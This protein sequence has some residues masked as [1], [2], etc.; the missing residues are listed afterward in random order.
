[1]DEV[2][3]ILRTYTDAMTW[4]LLAVMAVMLLLLYR[5]RWRDYALVRRPAAV[6]DEE[7]GADAF[8]RVSIVVPY[9]EGQGELV[10]AALPEFLMLDYPDFEVIATNC[11]TDREAADA[12]SRLCVRHRRLRATGIPSTM[13]DKGQA[14]L[15]VT[16]GV[17]AAYGEW[18][19]ILPPDARPASPDVL[20][21]MVQTALR[22]GL[23]V[24]QA[25]VN[26][27]DEG[28]RLSR[29]A[30]YARLLRQLT[31]L[32]AARRGA[33]IGSE[34]VGVLMRKEFFLAHCHA[35][36][37]LR[38]PFG[39]LDLMLDGQ[40]EPGK[41]RP[42]LSPETTILQPLPP[43]ALLSGLRHVERRL[44]RRRTFR[45]RL[46]LL[47]SRSTHLLLWLHLLSGCAYV[48]LRTWETLL[49]QAYTTS[50]LL[51]DA[52]FPLL[53]LA[54]LLL[55]ALLLRRSCRCLG[56]RSFGLYPYFADLFARP[57]GT[58]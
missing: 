23:D 16:L 3:E 55:P 8:P 1:M 39:A 33:P 34:L 18:V 32:R 10:A 36:R 11:S 56:E 22:D 49:A 26:F 37:V 28:T 47:R 58:L 13:R 42:M 14:W 5:W 15:G 45:A 50:R 54:A 43:R 52:L 17:R 24:V 51:P 4:G 12:I 41:L 48:G 29:R 38:E 2:L 19:A 7:G 27:V 40:P 46:F 44:R 53:F 6:R 21:R 35:P 25:Y 57:V 30:I 20:R 9:G 31:R